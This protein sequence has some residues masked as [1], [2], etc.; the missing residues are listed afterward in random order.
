[1]DDGAQVCSQC[2]KPAGA[3]SSS[4]VFTPNVGGVAVGPGNAQVQLADWG[5]RAAGW[6]IDLLLIIVPVIVGII[7][8]VAVKSFIL[9]VLFYLVAAA[10]GIWFSVQVGTTGQSPGMRV[11]GLK[12]VSTS[13]GAPI[14][15]G[16]GFARFIC[17]YITNWFC[18][19]GYLWAIWDKSHQTLA[20]KIVSTVVVVVPK[21]NFSLS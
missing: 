19:I 8:A 5:T 16:M 4:S 10:T 14:G 1:M 18:Y 12:C 17:Q 9:A 15:G 13:S 2:G 7:L 11:M 21:Q 20:D 3:S 6:F